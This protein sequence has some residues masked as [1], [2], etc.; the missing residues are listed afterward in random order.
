LKLRLVTA[1]A[2]IVGAIAASPAPVS[3]APKVRFGIIQYDSPGN[4]L[5][6]TNAKLNAEWVT[7]RNPKTTAVQIRGWR[8]ADASGHVYRFTRLR[9]GPGKAV[10]LHTGKGTNTRTDRYWGL[11]NYVWNNTGDTAR[12][13]NAAGILIDTCRWTSAGTGRIACP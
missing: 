3:A 11:E 4:D 5:P 8:V 9:L 1:A 2:L 7:I 6:V 10:R 12:L 13:R